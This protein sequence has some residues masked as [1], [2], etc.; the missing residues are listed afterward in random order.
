MPVLDNKRWKVPFEPL[1]LSEN[2]PLPSNIKA[3]K[4]NLKPLPSELKYVY[5]GQD[6]TYPVVISSQLDEEQ[7]SSLI[8][9]LKE[10]K[11]AIGWSI[12]DLKGIDC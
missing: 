4:L 5:L 10:H 11:N 6:E 9:T 1:P 2:K 12:A 7:E 3:P 8:T